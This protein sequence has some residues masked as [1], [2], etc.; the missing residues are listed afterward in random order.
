VRSVIAS[1]D[2]VNRRIERI[3]EQVRLGV[4]EV[5][6]VRANFEDITTTNQALVQFIEQV[7]GSA[8]AQATNA[9]RVAASII[10]MATTFRQ[11]NEM[12]VASGD[13][14]AHMRLIVANLQESV[15]T[16]KVDGTLLAEVSDEG[17]APSVE[18]AA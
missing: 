16:L 18:S 17:D 9:Q 14:M 13:E 15:S 11:F 4:D 6:S 10:A 7:A 8:H 1:I 5:R 2:A 12:L 3:S